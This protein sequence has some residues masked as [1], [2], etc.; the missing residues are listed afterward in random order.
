MNDRSKTVFE[1]SDYLRK[2]RNI[3]IQLVEAG[4]L[5]TVD[6][7][8]P[9]RVVQEELLSMIQELVERRNARPES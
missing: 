9:R 1:V 2:V 3:Y 8:R 4:K 5:V 6:A 7:D